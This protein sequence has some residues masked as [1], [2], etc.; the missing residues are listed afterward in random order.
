MRMAQETETRRRGRPPRTIA[1]ADAERARILKAAER[2]FAKEGYGGVS[3]RKVASAAGCSPAAL[4][5]LFPHKRALL[6]NIWDDALAALDRTLAR[7][8]RGAGDADAR[9]IRLARA[10]VEYWLAHRDHFRALFLIEDRVVDPGERYFVETSRNLTPMVARF[11]RAAEAAI[12]A[13]GA[14]ASPRAFMELV[15]CG[16]HGVTSALVGMPEYAWPQPAAFTERMIRSLLD[17]IR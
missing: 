9:L 12:A 10:Y 2:L 15:F 16:L 6:R 1:Q 8:E 7:R 4:Y 13:R 17:G 5:L 14:K 11:T 3:M